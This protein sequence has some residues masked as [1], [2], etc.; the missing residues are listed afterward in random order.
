MHW[1]CEMAEQIMLGGEL[2]P[3]SWKV[4]WL[5]SRDSP[6]LSQWPFSEVFSFRVMAKQRFGAVSS[7]VPVYCPGLCRASLY[8][9]VKVSLL[10]QAHGFLQ[11]KP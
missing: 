6:G 7:S 2:S 9:K 11:Q 1:V 5:T 8:P 3:Q 10:S 4:C